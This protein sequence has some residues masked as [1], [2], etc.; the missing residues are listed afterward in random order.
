MGKS[1]DGLAIVYTGPGK[2]KTTAALG[3]ALRVI[4][5]GGRVFLVQF[6]KGRATGELRAA[7]LLPGFDVVQVGRPAFVE[8]ARPSE[9]DRALARK[10]L[11]RAA[12]ALRSG[13]YRLVILDEVNV[14]AAHGLV[15]VDEVVNLLAQR[16]AGVDVVLTGREAPEEFVAAADL[17]TVMQE[18]KHPY[19]NGR[20]A[21][22]GIEY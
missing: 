9:A 19:R 3:L 5:H 21:R 2:G 11:E 7:A 18:I 20:S 22:A 8:L 10:G 17:V 6:L 1:E 12:E 15:G 16:P 14:A 4:G 13:A